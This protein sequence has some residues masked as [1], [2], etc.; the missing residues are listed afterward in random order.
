LF[1]TIGVGF[2]VTWGASALTTAIA[3]ASTSS[4]QAAF[5]WMGI[6]LLLILFWIWNLVGTWRSAG[7]QMERG[8]SLLWA[9]AAR[10]M[11]AV[12]LMF[13]TLQSPRLILQATELTSLALGQDPL[14]PV[15][16]MTASEDGS[17]IV[18]EGMLA[19]GAGMRFEELLAKSPNARLVSLKSTGG[20]LLEARMIAELIHRR[21]LATRV[22]S[23]CISACTLVLIAGVERSAEP[24]ARIGFHQPRFPGLSAAGRRKAI[25]RMRQLYREGGISDRFLE[26]VLNVPPEQ[27]WYPPRGRLVSE[28]VLNS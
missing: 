5:A 22:E 20:R 18:I 16:T 4:Q 2:V 14:G 27:I 24:D 6:G 15:A 26:E 13:L 17:E 12:G 7:S 1:I 3:E 11:V 28:G 9:T 23:R 8:G 21:Q 25:D 10:L 19:S